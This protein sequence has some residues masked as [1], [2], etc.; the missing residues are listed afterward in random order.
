MAFVVLLPVE[1]AKR[2]L[3]VV[4]SGYNYAHLKDSKHI[5]PMSIIK[6]NSDNRK[7]QFSAFN[8]HWNYWLLE[9][10]YNFNALNCMFRSSLPVVN[11]FI[12]KI[13]VYFFG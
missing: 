6:T 3:H 12:G 5:F 10:K 9:W 7:F 11:W 4:T 8:W 2:Q 1:R 13:Y